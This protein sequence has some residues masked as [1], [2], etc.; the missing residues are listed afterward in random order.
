MNSWTIKDVRFCSGFA[1]Y[2]F[3]GVD[4]RSIICYSPRQLN[5]LGRIRSTRMR[6]GIDD[7]LMESYE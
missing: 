6:E 2:S 7:S 4:P 5:E 1:L 3:A